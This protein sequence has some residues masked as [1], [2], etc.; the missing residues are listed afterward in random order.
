MNVTTFI[1]FG[2]GKFPKE[3]E[4]CAAMKCPHCKKKSHLAFACIC[5]VEFCVKCRTPEVHVC[6]VKEEKKVE[7]EKVVAD[8]LPDRI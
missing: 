2:N 6:I 4:E 5:G 1:V 8:K 3:E 7:L